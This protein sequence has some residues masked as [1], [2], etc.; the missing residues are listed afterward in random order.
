[1]NVYAPGAAGALGYYGSFFSDVDQSVV[2]IDTPKAMTLNNT[3]EANGISIVSDSRITFAY[4]GTYDLQFSA[5]VQHRGG[6]GNGTELD[7]WLAKNGTAVADSATKLIVPKNRYSVPAWDFLLTLEAGDYLELYWMV[8]NTDIVLEHGDAAGGH[9]DI[10]SLIVNV[11]QVM[12][13]QVGPVGPTGATGATG[14]AGAAATVAAGTTTT[15]SPGASATVANAGT[16]SAAVFNFGIPAGVKGDQ[17]D[18]GDDSTITVGTT[19]TLSAGSS[20]TVANSGTASAAILDFGIPQGLV[21][22]TGA[23]GA[24][25]AAA[26]IAVGTTTTLSAGSSATVTNAGT[27]S[28]AVF[29]F[30][31]PQ[32]IQGE[33]GA[34]GAAGANPAPDDDQLVL[35]YQVFS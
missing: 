20:A 8:D 28:A 30:G 24:P 34:T 35:A 14:A 21:G 12:Y 4:D 9:P 16:S 17:G 19:T 7:I 6:G 5:Q 33:T 22:A 26:T 31:I 15:L 29:D 32:G 23:N 10:P 18:P 3:A 25:G 13:T 1:V 2:A 27:S 11:M